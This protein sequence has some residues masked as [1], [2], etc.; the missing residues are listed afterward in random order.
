[1]N[2]RDRSPLS[3]GG[4]P[5]DTQDSRGEGGEESL[6]REAGRGHSTVTASLAP[7]IIRLQGLPTGGQASC[8]RRARVSR[9]R[10]LPAHAGAVR[11][12]SA[13]RCDAP[14]FSDPAVSLSCRLLQQHER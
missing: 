3:G 8:M 5:G 7:C 9:V 13:R 1:M 14:A 12:C 2:R 11:H 4:G 10:T 6:D